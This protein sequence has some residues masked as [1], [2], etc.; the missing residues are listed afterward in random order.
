MIVRCT[1]TAKFKV[2]A[3][4]EIFQVK[5]EDLD[6]E[7]DGGDERP[8]GAELTHQA[9]FTHS[10]KDAQEYDVTWRIW[11]Y[12]EGAEN[13][14]ETEPDGR[15]DL[16]ENFDFFLEHTPDRDD[17]SCDTSNFQ[18]LFEQLN[19][20]QKRRLVEGIRV[21]VEAA[22]NEAVKHADALPQYQISLL[23]HTQRL[24]TVVQ[25]CETASRDLRKDQNAPLI[26]LWDKVARYERGDNFS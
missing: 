23:P 14:K 13:D 3:T 22:K 21:F 19:P 16:I 4:G 17:N 8:M 26:D 11:E 1:G 10:S 12:P 25:A 20:S 9:E 15:L 5:P 18:S 6:W 7:I 2:R 24:L